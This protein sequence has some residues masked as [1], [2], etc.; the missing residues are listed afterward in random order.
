MISILFKDLV[1]LKDQLRSITGIQNLTTA[2]KIGKHFIDF[3]LGIGK[4]LRAINVQAY[5]VSKSHNYWILVALEY[6]TVESI[7]EGEPEQK[8]Q[9]EILPSIISIIEDQSDLNINNLHY[10]F[11]LSR[12]FIYRENRQSHLP[13]YRKRHFIFGKN[14]LVQEVFNKDIPGGEN[15]TYVL[16]SDAINYRIQ[17]GFEVYQDEREPVVFDVLLL[18]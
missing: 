12:D 8:I 7:W 10:L 4:V 2:K 1:E 16:T 13:L 3:P 11:T 17:Y 15:V 5:D 14:F 18:N 6:K 9:Q